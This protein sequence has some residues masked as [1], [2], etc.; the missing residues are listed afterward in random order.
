MVIIL[1]FSIWYFTHYNNKNIIV[2][3]VVNWNYWNFSVS[4]KYDF[5]SQAIIAMNSKYT[6]T[7]ILTIEVNRKLRLSAGL[8]TIR[9]YIVIIIVDQWFIYYKMDLQL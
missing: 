9:V 1:Y 4:G 2:I 8:Q 6:W 3:F 7:C 5:N